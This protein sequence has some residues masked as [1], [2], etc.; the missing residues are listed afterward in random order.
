MNTNQN[1]RLVVS[2]LLLIIVVSCNNEPKITPIPSILGE[3]HFV[4]SS[5][6]IIESM[7]ADIT[8]SA[9]DVTGLKWTFF[10]DDSLIVESPN[11]YW[12]DWY[13]FDAELM[14]LQFSDGTYDV[15]TLENDSLNLRFYTEHNAGPSGF[16]NLYIY[17]NLTR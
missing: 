13:H 11:A 14:Q 6:E 4:E 17:F 7:P 12:K 9:P 5:I 1:L 3:W 16:I 2:A 15:L 10:S 8:I